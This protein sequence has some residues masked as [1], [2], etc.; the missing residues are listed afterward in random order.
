[1][2][3]EAIYHN[4]L[5]FIVLMFPFVVVPNYRN[6]QVVSVPSLRWGL[7][8]LFVAVYCMANEPIYLNSWTD[9]G[10]YGTGFVNLQR[11]GYQFD[12]LNGETLFTFYSWIVSFF[13]DYHGWFYITAIIYVGSYLIV[14]K[15]L[16]REYA[17]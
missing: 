11:D 16:T 12:G 1:M 15:R 10:A 7:L 4:F 3:F 2:N 9:R 6:N 8:F 13:T 5:L 17:F 14:A